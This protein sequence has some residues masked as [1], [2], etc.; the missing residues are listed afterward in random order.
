MK[1]NLL[2]ERLGDREY[3][4]VFAATKQCEEIG[5]AEKQFEEAWGLEELIDSILDFVGVPEDTSDFPIRGRCFE[6]TRFRDV[7][8]LKKSGKLNCEKALRKL[9]K[10]LIALRELEL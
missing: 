9:G 6:R 7:F 2:R 8:R 1:V 3:N 10:M 5:K 4:F